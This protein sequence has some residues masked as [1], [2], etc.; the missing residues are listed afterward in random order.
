MYWVFLILF[1]IAVLIPDIIRGPVYFLEE[2]RAEEIVI[3]LMGAIGF[4][5]F[6]RNEYRISVQKK[7]KEK[8][9]KRM[10]QTVKDLVESYSYIGEVNRKMDILM[11]IALGLSDRSTLNKNRE[12]EIYESIISAGNFLLKADCSFL[13]F[14]DQRDLKN[15][16]EIKLDK[17]KNPVKNE[18]LAGMGENIN[19]K[20]YG[21]CIVISSPQKINNIKSYLIICGYDEEEVANPKNMEIL[22]VFA[23][24]ALFLYS[25]L[26]L[27]NGNRN[28][29]N[30]RD[31]NLN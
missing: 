14:V 23:S 9:E 27:E 10:K 2:E 3:F 16:K 20:K 25:Y 24:Q 11:S 7:E 22:K 29:E 28:K 4:L 1:I 19:I 5:V 15:L 12:K 6:M 13:Q 30:E 8:E 21:D 18:E 31:N 26:S 17:K